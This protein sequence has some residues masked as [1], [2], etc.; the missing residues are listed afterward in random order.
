MSDEPQTAS[1]RATFIVRRILAAM[2]DFAATYPPLPAQPKRRGDPSRMGQDLPPL[3]ALVVVEGKRTLA[4]TGWRRV[5]VCEVDWTI[6]GA[7]PRAASREL[8]DALE[9]YTE[10]RLSVDDVKAVYQTFADAH[11]IFWLDGRV[12]YDEFAAEIAAYEQIRMVAEKNTAARVA[13]TPST[14][15]EPRRRPRLA[16]SRGRAQGDN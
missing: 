14:V 5:P 11:L 13:H 16:Y 4:S 15:A 6:D 3:Y 2:I 10:G 12:F 8:G 1:E 9:G 7:R